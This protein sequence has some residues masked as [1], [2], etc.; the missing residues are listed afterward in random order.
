MLLLHDNLH[1]VAYPFKAW[2]FCNAQDFC[3]LFSEPELFM[4]F[5][6]ECHGNEKVTCGD[7]TVNSDGSWQRDASFLMPFEA[8]AWLKKVVGKLQSLCPIS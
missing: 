6:R 4:S 2:L 7:W 1:V 8:P 3:E 5:H